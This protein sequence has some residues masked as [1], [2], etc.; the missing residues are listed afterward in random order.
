[1]SRAHLFHYPF[2]RR[3]LRAAY[4]PSSGPSGRALHN[5]VRTDPPADFLHPTTPTWRPSRLGQSLEWASD[6]NNSCIDVGDLTDFRFDANDEW[7][8]IA[9]GL[10]TDTAADDR[11]IIAKWNVSTSSNRQLLLRTDLG[12]APTDVEVRMN[13][14][15]LSF[16]SG[17]VVELNTFYAFCLANHLGTVTLNIYEAFNGNLLDTS[18]GTAANAAT[19]T[20]P[21]Q[22]WGRTNNDEWRGIGGPVYL[23]TRALNDY[24][25]Q[26]IARIPHA[27]LH[28]KR[29][30]RGFVPAGA[31]QTINVGQ[32]TETDTAQA[33][34]KAKVKA[35]GQI[36]ETDTAQAFTVVKGVDVGQAVETDTPQ[37]FG[38]A[39]QKEFGQITEADT[40]QTITPVSGQ[41]IVVNQVVETDTAQ[42]FTIN[43][44][45][46]LVTQIAETDTP[47]TLTTIGGAAAV[48][49][50]GGW[51]RRRDYEWLRRLGQPPDVVERLEAT[52]DE[53]AEILP[54]V[55]RDD[56]P[57]TEPTLGLEALEEDLDA[58]AVLADSLEQEHRA[59]AETL[60]EVAAQ[61]EDEQM[62]VVL[63]L[64][65]EV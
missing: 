59:L 61:I 60:R 62:A 56:I 16:S 30:V 52:L 12:A 35:F 15:A 28:R 24:E 45:R 65:M 41:N 44:Q 19:Q 9:I 29:P 6:V 4:T 57:V 49:P 18:S 33:F 34:G 1:M 31:G 7:T 40:S 25:Q 38:K 11:S 22:L 21:I 20:N 43:P 3:G 32:V 37:A 53:A 17:L 5:S 14:S 23:Y 51:L 10:L 13:N 50:V 36:A 27:P 63:M 2:L 58:L 39:K 64:A 42:A 8:A 48:Q 46:R 55:I 26:L 54:P 47:L